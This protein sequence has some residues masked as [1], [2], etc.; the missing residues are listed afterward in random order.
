MFRQGRLTPPLTDL[1]LSA[2]IYSPLRE[3]AVLLYTSDGGYAA[4]CTTPETAVPEAQGWVQTIIKRAGE[5]IIDTMPSIITFP[6]MLDMTSCCCLTYVTNL[7]QL[8]NVLF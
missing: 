5:C 7:Y 4:L 8:R 2:H 6:D 3:G 1:Y